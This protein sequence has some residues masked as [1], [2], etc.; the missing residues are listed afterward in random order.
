LLVIVVS[1]IWLIATTY[2]YS[3]MMR[4]DTRPGMAGNPPLRWPATSQV[5]L[6]KAQRTLL[7]F[8]HPKCSCSRASISQLQNLQKRLPGKFHTELVLWQPLN[9]S[10]SWNQLYRTDMGELTG[11]QVITDPGGRAAALFDVHTSGYVLLYG[12]GGDLQYAGGLTLARAFDLEGPGIVAMEQIMA[13]SKTTAAHRP[14]YGCS[15]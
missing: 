15:F 6:A 7:V 9:P 12:A 11:T 3:V 2:A 8:L 13:G 14:V 4:F 1:A 5:K 10:P